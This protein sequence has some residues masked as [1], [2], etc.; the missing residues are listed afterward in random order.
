[1]LLWMVILIDRNLGYYYHLLTL[2]VKM[3]NSIC[4]QLA[5]L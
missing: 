2:L 3:V 4:Y 1:M 5:I